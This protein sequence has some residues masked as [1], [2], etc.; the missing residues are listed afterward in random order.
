MD[1]DTARRLLKQNKY[2]LPSESRWKV[3]V[4]KVSQANGKDLVT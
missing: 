1:I 4:L 2:N 3:F